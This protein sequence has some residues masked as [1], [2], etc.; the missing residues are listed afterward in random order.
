MPK[1]ENFWY[2]IV[3]I[4]ELGVDA[5]KIGG[6]EWSARGVKYIKG[7]VDEFA[8]FAEALVYGPDIRRLLA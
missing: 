4:Q 1:S 5:Q 8:Q 2:T 3:P 7:L 6:R